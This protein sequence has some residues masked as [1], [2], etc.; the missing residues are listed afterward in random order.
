MSKLNGCQCFTI[1]LLYYVGCKS[2]KSDCQDSDPRQ[3]ASITLGLYSCNTIIWH[4]LFLPHC[5]IHLISY[6]STLWRQKTQE[7]KKSKKIRKSDKKLTVKNLQFFFISVKYHTSLNIAVIFLLILCQEFAFLFQHTYTLYL[8]KSM[9]NISK[10]K[11]EMK[12]DVLWPTS[13]A[14]ALKRF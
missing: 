2:S 10:L 4:C 9:K 7:S 8:Y 6:R 5:L 13:L 11:S 3:R 12:S 1:S 14:K